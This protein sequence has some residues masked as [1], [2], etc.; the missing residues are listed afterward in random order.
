MSQRK[1]LSAGSMTLV[2]AVATRQPFRCVWALPP[3]HAKADM[4]D[5]EEGTQQDLES[6]QKRQVSD[7]VAYWKLPQP[8]VP[9]PGL[10]LPL[11]RPTR[12]GT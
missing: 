4:W 2:A 11:G 9:I 5:D 12:A 8:L 10:H 3:R 6:M 7:S 1:A